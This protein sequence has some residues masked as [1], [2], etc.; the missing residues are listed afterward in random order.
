VTL[1]SKFHPIWCI[2][3]QE[4][5]LR[6]RF[7]SGPDISDRFFGYIHWNR[8]YPVQDRTCL[9]DSFQPNVYSLFWPYFVNRVSVWPHSFSASFVIL[10]GSFLSC[11]FVFFITFLQGFLIGVLK[12]GRRMI[13]AKEF[14]S[15]PVH[16]PPVVS[17]VL[18]LVSE[19]VWLLVGF[20][21]LY[22]P[23]ATWR[24]VP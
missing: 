24:K 8:T 9:L 7:L 20:N 12:V 2:V 5:K 18:Q 15:A 21:S 19:P 6:R 23:K 16:P 11:W 13:L 17:L 4:S 22:D 14:N 3:A 10:W 1:V